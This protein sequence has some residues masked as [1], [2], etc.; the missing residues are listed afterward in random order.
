MNVSKWSARK[1]PSPKGVW[2]F[3][4]SLPDADVSPSDN[5][6]LSGQIWDILLRELRFRNEV[7]TEGQ[8][9]EE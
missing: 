3:A 6:D 8:S 4:S 1:N 7:G 5:D 9:V 2:Y